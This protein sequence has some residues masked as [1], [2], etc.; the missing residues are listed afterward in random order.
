MFPLRL[1]YCT[2]EYS[3]D[4]Q[5]TYNFVPVGNGSMTYSEELC[6]TGTV[7]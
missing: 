2:V 4:F 7:L 3:P 6:I 5:Y 1:E